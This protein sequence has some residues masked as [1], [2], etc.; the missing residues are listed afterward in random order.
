MKL[1]PQIQDIIHHL[2]SYAGE[3]NPKAYID[4]ELNI[5]NKFDEHDLSEK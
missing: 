4:W 1:H 5:N 2:P 3:F